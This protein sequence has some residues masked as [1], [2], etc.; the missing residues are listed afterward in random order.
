MRK[1]FTAKS[2]LYQDDLAYIHADGY[3]FHS[4]GAGDAIL[5]WLKHFNMPSGMVVDLGCGGGQWIERLN[6]SGYDTCGIDISPSMI[7]LAKRNS[8]T[9]KLVC[10]SFSD[11]TIPDCDAATSLGEPLNYLR[12]GP[13]MR[14][15]MRNVF[16]ALR[17]G[18][19]FIFDVRH[20]TSAPV[21]V[22]ETHK[23]SKEW[24]CHAR[25]EEDSRKGELIRFI[26]TFRQTA[27]GDY[28]RNEEV[29]RLKLFP[30]G[31]I[32]QWLRR[33]GFRVKTARCY[34]TYQMGPRQSVFI[35]RKP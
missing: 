24:F 16:A 17:P 3:G 7:R 15:T 13:A 2:Q 21:G 26:T 32:T 6:Q 25:I 9:S 27:E 18:G 29:H 34:G 12:S 8:P 19:V 35:C 23:S 33:I 20:P 22:R 4:A 30:R 14:R 28:C 1:G 11:V 10:G 5:G 31:E